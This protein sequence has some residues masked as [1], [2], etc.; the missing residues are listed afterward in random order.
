M[1]DPSTFGTTILYSGVVLLSV[2]PPSLQLEQRITCK[3]VHIAIIMHR[4][5]RKET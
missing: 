4:K 1:Y 5:H 2:L 3:C